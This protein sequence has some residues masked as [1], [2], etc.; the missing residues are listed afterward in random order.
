MIFP[1]Y[2]KEPGVELPADGDYYIIARDGVYLHRS[3]GFITAT[4]KVEQI[5]ALAEVTRQAQL[6]LPPLDLRFVCYVVNFFRAIY[7]DIKT[8]AA[9]LVFWNPTNQ[10]YRVAA[11]DQFVSIGSVNYDKGLRYKDH[12]L[13]GSIHSHANFSAFHSGTDRCDEQYFDGLHVTIGHLDD[14]THDISAEIAVNG[15]RFPVPPEAYLQGIERVIPVGVNVKATERSREP[16]PARGEKRTLVERIFGLDPIMLD[17]F[18]E[19]DLGFPRFGK[20][21]EPELPR[22]RFITESDRTLAS[23]AFPPLWRRRVR[24]RSLIALLRDHKEKDPRPEMLFSTL[25]DEGGGG[26]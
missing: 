2:V 20:K 15:N 10:T 6:R 25:G 22:F 14:K 26:R 17:D 23:Y 21:K 7:H 19:S 11:P 4:V 9:V 24:E 5:S 8:E 13:I 1:I 12:L 18:S 3:E 16:L